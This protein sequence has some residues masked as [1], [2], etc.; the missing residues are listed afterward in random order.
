MAHIHKTTSLQCAG[1][2]NKAPA[3]DIRKAATGAGSSTRP[4]LEIVVR[5]HD[6]EYG[7]TWNS[8]WIFLLAILWSTFTT[9]IHSFSHCGPSYQLAIGK[10]SKLRDEDFD[11]LI[12]AG[13]HKP[14]GEPSCL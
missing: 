10:R 14:Q 11:L 12:Q 6:E 5:I 1:Y 2:Q 13:L 4:Q 8:G 7:H 9:H 3:I